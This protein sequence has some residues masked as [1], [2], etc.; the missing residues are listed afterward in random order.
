M[1]SFAMSN[2]QRVYVLNGLPTCAE[3]PGLDANNISL[4]HAGT[5]LIKA[6]KNYAEIHVESI[7]VY[8][9]IQQFFNIHTT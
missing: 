6:S 7:D 9:V 1:V 4:H 3:W 5:K 2:D 8:N